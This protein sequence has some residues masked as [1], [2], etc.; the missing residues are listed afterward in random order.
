MAETGN[1]Q[2]V[3]A[4]FVVMVQDAFGNVLGVVVTYVFTRTRWAVVEE[5]AYFLN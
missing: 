1:F 4:D 2:P 3:L 5:I